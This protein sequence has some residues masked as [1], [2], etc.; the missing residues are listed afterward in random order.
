MAV[1][2]NIDDVSFVEKP[3][4]PPEMPDR[5]G[6]ALASMGVY[7]FKRELL[8]DQLQRDAADPRSSRDFGRDIIPWLVTHGKTNQAKEREA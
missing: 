8:N 1:A 3:A 4:H 6:W 5:P 7:A 2:I